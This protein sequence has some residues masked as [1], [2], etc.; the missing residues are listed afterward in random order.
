[1]LC[2]GGPTSALAVCRVRTACSTSE[3]MGASDT[4]VPPATAMS[5]SAGV[6]VSSSAK[7]I[8]ASAALTFRTALVMTASTTRSTT[9]SADT[10]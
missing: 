5:V 3:F 2:G 6:H 8:D 10:D 9:I 4:E 7:T 1:M